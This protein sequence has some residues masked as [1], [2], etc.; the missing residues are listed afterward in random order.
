MGSTRDKDKGVNVQVLLRCRPFSEDELKNKV[1]QVVSCHEYSGE[2][3]VCQNLQNKTIDRTFTFDKV[4]GP[5]SEQKDVYD[6]AIIPIVQEVLAGFNCTVFAYGQT[7]TGK[8]YTMEGK[9]RKTVKLGDPELPPEAG[10]IPRAVQQIFDTLESQNAEYSVLVSFIELYNEEITD[11]LAPEEIFV[12]GKEDKRKPLALM[13]DGKGGV[14]VRGLEEEVVVNAGDL[15]ALLD[16]GSAKRR[17]AETLMNKQSSRSHSIFSI[18]INI[19]EN[20]PQGEEVIKCGKLNLVDLAG[21]ENISRSGAREGRAREAGEINKSLLTLS[22]V[23]TALVEHLAHVPYRDSKLTRL[24][25][26]SL[27]G[28]TK[29]CIIATVAPSIQ[30][31]EETLSTLDYAHRAKNIR[32]K[33]EVNQKV[34]KAALIK[35]LYGEIEKLKA[36]VYA[37]REKNGIYLPRER[38]FQDEAE[39]KAMAERLEIMEYE[40]EAKDKQIEGLQYQCESKRQQQLDIS[41]RLEASQQAYERCQEALMEAR[42]GV[43]RANYTIREYEFVMST[44]HQSELSLAGQAADLRSELETTVKDLTQL[45]SLLDSKSKLLAGNHRSVENFQGLFREKIKSLHSIMNGS[46]KAQHELLQNMENQLQSFLS[47]KDQSGDEVRRKLEALRST[48][49]T[50]SRSLYD[51]V[52]THEAQSSSTIHKLNNSVSVQFSTLDQLLA[53]QVAEADQVLTELQNSL[54]EQQQQIATFIQKHREIAERTMDSGKII[55]GVIVDSLQML[56]TSALQF[57]DNMDSK[58][59]AQDESL[60]QLTKAYEEQAMQERNQLLEGIAELIT[61]SMTRNSELVE[62]RVSNIRETAKANAIE[63]KKSMISIQDSA[64]AAR[65]HFDSLLRVT[66]TSTVETSSLLEAT[67][68][69]MDELQQTSITC[70][71][72]AQQQWKTTHESLVQ[73]ERE[74]FLSKGS[75]LTEG[76]EAN[77]FLVARCAALHAAMEGD[78]EEETKDAISFLENVRRS[79]HEVVA[80]LSA[81]METQMQAIARL[82]SSHGSHVT[83]LAQVTEHTFRNEY[84]FTVSEDEA[85]SITT[86]R[87]INVPSEA[88][89]NSLRTPGLEYLQ[90]EFRSKFSQP[91]QDYLEGQQKQLSNGNGKLSNGHMSMSM[92][93]STSDLRDYRIPLTAVN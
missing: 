72:T 25:R 44:Q 28:K 67:Q 36:E 38:Y 83:D 31:L 42:D 79:E 5:E 85:K 52:C 1:P 81:V 22:R 54:V 35:D 21:S 73:C 93:M 16:R 33:P 11:L 86:A 89:I 75:I 43:K 12:K 87:K 71:S 64:S 70:A 77:Q 50:Q 60:A 46:I 18:T 58:I 92:S 29:T 78:V 39:K 14:L 63:T 30:C 13:E 91:D 45:F 27:G 88:A 55:S 90:Q 37:A 24:L 53:N 76:L 34:T 3:T 19:K 4:F 49:L 47:V 74:H 32:N 57:T 20:T 82:E 7:G 80:E 59:Y 51:V 65:E 68:N 40:A 2:V 10:V 8:T 66:E 56:Y 62:S 69:R 9:G 17:V 15:Y 84:Q 6:S 48:Y 23:I 41:S 26:D 61:N